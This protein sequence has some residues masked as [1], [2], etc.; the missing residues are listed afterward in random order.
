MWMYGPYPK[1]TQV[2]RLKILRRSGELWLRNSAKCPRNFGRR[3]TTRLRHFLRV[4]GVVGSQR[5][6]GSDCLSKTQKNRNHTNHTPTTTTNQQRPATNGDNSMRF[7]ARVHYTVLTQHPTQ[8]NNHQSQSGHYIRV[9]YNQGI[10][11][12]TPNNAPSTSNKRV[13]WQLINC[14]WLRRI[15][16]RFNKKW[17]QN[18]RLLNHHTTTTTT[19]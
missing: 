9:G 3:G 11:P 19:K 2:V 7:N 18:N 10:M 16:T 17:Q 5:I 8:A 6:E 4:F 1:P 14:F 12:Q 13:D 15:S